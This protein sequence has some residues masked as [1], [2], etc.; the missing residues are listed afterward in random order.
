[1]GGEQV[2]LILKCL[3]KVIAIILG[4]KYFLLKNLHLS[5]PGTP[6]SYYQ[7]TTLFS[8]FTELWGSLHSHFGL[9]QG[10]L[11]NCEGDRCMPCDGFS[12]FI[13]AG[14]SSDA[15]AVQCNLLFL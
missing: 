12:L 10:V 6:L 11:Q 4:V 7:G 14:V 1:M 5:V 15:K 2:T 13:N 9:V 3:Q 8:N